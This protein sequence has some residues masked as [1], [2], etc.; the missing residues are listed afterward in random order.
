MNSIIK[1][2]S[3]S[4]LGVRFDSKL[5]FSDHINDKI[6]KAYSVLGVIK[7]NF[8]IYGQNYIYPTL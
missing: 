1:V 6:N 5:T 4:D 3:F 8:Y 2:D 7:R